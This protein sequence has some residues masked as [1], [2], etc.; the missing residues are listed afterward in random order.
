MYKQVTDLMGGGRVLPRDTGR[1]GASAFVLQGARQLPLSSL[2]DA[3]AMLQA[4]EAH[5]RYAAT[6]MNEHSSRA[7][8]LFL[9][10]LQQ[11]AAPC[12]RGDNPRCW[13]R[14][15]RV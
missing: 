2:A 4:G 13:R 3:L 12:A 8:T 15:P 7:H 9:L 5:K 14:Q 1:G 6:A 10:S 11:A